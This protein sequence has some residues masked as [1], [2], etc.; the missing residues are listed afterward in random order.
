VDGKSSTKSLVVKRKY[1]DQLPVMYRV[2][3]EFVSSRLVRSEAHRLAL[4]D[5]TARNRAR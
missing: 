2:G 1:F 4:G 3:R 5:Q